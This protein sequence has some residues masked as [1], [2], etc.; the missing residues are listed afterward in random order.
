MNEIT[1]NPAGLLGGLHAPFDKNSILFGMVTILILWVGA[2][3]IGTLSGEDYLIARTGYW[4]ATQLGNPGSTCFEFLYGYAPCYKA[5]LDTLRQAPSHTAI[6]FMLSWLILLFTFCGGVICRKVAMRLGKDERISIKKAIAY[7]WKHKGGLW[8]TPLMLLIIAVLLYLVNMLLGYIAQ[9]IPILGTILYVVFFIVAVILSQVI[10]IAIMAF[11]FG[12]PLMPAAVGSDGSDWVEINIGIINYMFARPWLYILYSFLMFAS[13]VILLIASS[14]LCNLVFYSTIGNQ[15]DEIAMYYI[16]K[17]WETIKIQYVKQDTLAIYYQGEGLNKQQAG[18]SQK[19]TT[20]ETDKAELPQKILQPYQVG[21]A[22][23]WACLQ[24]TPVELW[25]YDEKENETILQEMQMSVSILWRWNKYW[26]IVAGVIVFLHWLLQICVWGY[27]F[28]SLCSASTS[29]YLALRKEVDG[30]EQSEIWDEEAETELADALQSY[31]QQHSLNAVT[32]ANPTTEKSQDSATQS[33]LLPTKNTAPATQNLPPASKSTAP[34][35]SLSAV[36]QSAKA[37]QLLSKAPSPNPAIP[38]ASSPEA[39]NIATV[40]QPHANVADTITPQF[41][42]PG[43][44][45]ILPLGQFI[46]SNDL[47]ATTSSTA[48]KQ[49][50]ISLPPETTTSTSA[51]VAIVTPNINER[52]PAVSAFTLGALGIPAADVTATAKITVPAPAPKSLAEKLRS[53]PPAPPSPYDLNISEIP[54][55]IPS[56][57]AQVNAPDSSTT[58]D[59]YILHDPNA[60]NTTQ[61]IE[62][63]VPSTNRDFMPSLNESVEMPADTLITSGQSISLPIIDAIADGQENVELV[64]TAADENVALAESSTEQQ[65]SSTQNATNEPIHDNTLS[66]GFN[67]PKA[68]DEQLDSTSSQNSAQD[69][70]P[71][72]SLVVEHKDVVKHE[73][74]TMSIRLVPRSSRTEKKADEKKSAEKKTTPYLD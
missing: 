51:E 70:S 44:T 69:A 45:S 43:P 73:S 14:A 3:I 37:S 15:Q 35:H 19:Q 42:R 53:A 58:G 61:A 38:S 34:S 10:I 52:T 4:V 39:K 25:W 8:I 6:F 2:A 67:L 60:T 11:L 41:N 31:S 50:N 32:Q 56:D 24:N 21:F 54:P 28:A 49:E 40:E 23:V 12:L 18:D 72:P 59:T 65:P 47:T 26:G 16:D 22:E 5:P 13:L 66:S 29:M 63:N 30:I 71:D 57:S 20:G 1:H 36:I 74:G 9:A 17:R 27:I 33:P 7:A 68:S 64:N 62:H 46:A 55:T 48:D